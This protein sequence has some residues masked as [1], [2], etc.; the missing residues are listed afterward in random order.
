MDV[1][2]T[3][4]VIEIMAYLAGRDLQ[5]FRLVSWRFAIVGFPTLARHLRVSNAVSCLREFYGFLAT[6]P[7]QYTKTLAIQHSRWP[8][9][10]RNDWETHPLLRYERI[11][12]P[13]SSPTSTSHV[14]ITLAY[15]GFL[16]REERRDDESTMDIIARILSRLPAL[17]HITF[18]TLHTWG[19]VPKRLTP[20]LNRTMN[21]M[22]PCVIRSLHKSPK[23]KSLG[24]RGKTPQAVL[25]RFPLPSTVT[26][27]RIIS[28]VGG[29]LARD[30]TALSIPSQPRLRVLEV[31][32]PARRRPVS[33]IHSLPNLESLSLKGCVV[34]EELLVEQST[35]PALR[36]LALSNLTLSNGTWESF[37][38]RFR[39][40]GPRLTLELDGM[41]DSYEQ[42]SW[43]MCFHP[44]SR[45]T[46]ML[47]RFLQYKT[48][49]PY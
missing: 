49:W 19:Q 39:A 11:V 29:P 24:F 3:E 33:F 42:P 22:V 28:L 25:H 5:S 48:P 47:N 18:E 36:K 45:S 37:L 44:R 12:H 26:T 8:M 43:D 34:T 23:V 14:N 4:L 40:L 41:F 21:R 17:T 38:F 7:T 31:S 1:I 35:E 10:A 46:H 2:S 9:F 30:S 32:C 6:V 13:P 16:E 27:F 15:N 20:I